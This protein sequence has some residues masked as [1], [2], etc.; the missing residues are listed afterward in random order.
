[1]RA[2]AFGTV[3]FDKEIGLRLLSPLVLP[4]VELRSSPGAIGQ[5][6]SGFRAL[7]FLVVLPAPGPPPLKSLSLE[8][9]IA[10]VL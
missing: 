1:M 5:S 6:L 3:L 9:V 4:E 2:E 10:E 7:Q 8:F